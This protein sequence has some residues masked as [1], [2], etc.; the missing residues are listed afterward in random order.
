MYNSVF[1]VFFSFFFILN[2]QNLPKRISV[3]GGGRPSTMDINSP[4]IPAP[5]VFV[6]AGPV[7]A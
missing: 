2:A 1:I 4:L 3:P 7:T 6:M 5:T